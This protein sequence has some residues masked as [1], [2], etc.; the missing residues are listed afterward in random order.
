[1]LA[2]AG[3]FGEQTIRHRLVGQYTVKVGDLC[4]VAVG[5]ITNR[6]Y[7]AVRQPFMPFGFVSGADVNSTV[8]NK[9]V[10]AAVRAIWGKSDY[11]QK[12]LDSLLL[13]FQTG[14]D[15]RA[16]TRLLF[17]FPDFAEDLIL[18]RLDEAEK[19]DDVLV[20]AVSWSTSPKLKGEAVGDLPQDRGPGDHGGCHAGAGQGA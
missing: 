7:A 14:N 17:Y 20:G 8:E 2:R 5:Q 15:A 3:L 16:A 1:M 19:P 10:A 6:E 11:R 12:L 9:E 4:F 18:A 13:D